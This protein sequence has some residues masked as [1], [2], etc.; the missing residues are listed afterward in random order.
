[1]LPW[2]FC[3]VQCKKQ[4]WDF[5]KIIA[6]SQVLCKNTFMSGHE[7]TLSVDKIKEKLSP[8][9]KEEGLQLVILFGSAASGKVHKRSDIDLALIFDNPIDM[10]GNYK[11]DYRSL[12]YRQH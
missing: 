8:L 3:A 9:F 5:Y 10:F 12:T 2:I 11:Q 7:N 1:M 4:V 6:F